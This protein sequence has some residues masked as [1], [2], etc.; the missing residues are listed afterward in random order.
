MKTT[1]TL[2]TD[3]LLA[4]VSTLHAVDVQK[5]ATS[6]RHNVVLFLILGAPSMT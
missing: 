4:P 2:L 5:P 6:C 1:L 3:L